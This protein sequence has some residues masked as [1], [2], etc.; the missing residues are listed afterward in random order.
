M[1]VAGLLSTTNPF[2]KRQRVVVFFLSFF[3]MRAIVVTD[4]AIV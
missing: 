3:L 4:F 1:S 2:A